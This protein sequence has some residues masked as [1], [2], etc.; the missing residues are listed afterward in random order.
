MSFLQRTLDEVSLR[1]ARL[2]VLLSMSL[3]GHR[4]GRMI[5][6]PFL[7]GGF[8]PVGDETTVEDLPVRGAIP[9]ELDGVYLRNGPNPAFKPLS[10]MF[11]FDGDG[12]VHALRLRDGRAAYRNRFVMTPGLRAERRAGRAIYGGVMTPHPVDPALVGADGDPGPFKNTANTNIVRHAGHIL[13]LWEGGPAT[14]LD[15]G[16]QTRGPFDFAGQLPH[17]MTAHPKFDPA[18]GEM[19]AFRYASVPPYLV[20]TVIDAAGG[21]KRQ[22]PLELDASFM[23][24]DFAVTERHAV[25]FLCPVVLDVAGA[26]RGGRLLDW[27]PA[28]GTRIGVVPRDGAGPVRWFDAEPFFV[29]HFMNAYEQDGRITVDYIQHAGFGRGSGAPPC[30]WRMELDL[31]AGTARRHQLADRS[32]EFPRIDPALEGRANR[33][34]WSLVRGARR[35]L[36]GTFGALARYD[37][38]GGRLVVHDFGFGQE[39]DEP[40]FIPRAG[41]TREADGWIGAYVYDHA[42]GT[43]RFV[44][45][46]AIDLAAPPV[47]EIAL[48]RRVPHGFHGNW[49]AG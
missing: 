39:V 23:V 4:L 1:A 9:S 3:S 26:V 7:E 19:L 5:P 37:L 14:E 20:F 11:P 32:A 24:H 31:T 48:P 33:A 6:N 35:G 13:A 28:R 2:R 12:M 36:P 44:L 29:F 47:A 41:A 42:G 17:A 15:A 43:S 30:L 10:Y 34:G 22:V 45:L 27:Q 8:A 46:D 38:A 18:T 40:V 21:V 16:L 49:M 25:F